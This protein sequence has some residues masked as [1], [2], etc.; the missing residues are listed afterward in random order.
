M[1][2]PKKAVKALTGATIR[3]VYY[4]EGQPGGHNNDLIKLT[5][6][7]GKVVC[8]DAYAMTGI[9]VTIEEE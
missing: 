7:G 6:E 9:V 3:D 8:V 1:E 5:L 4:H 2:M